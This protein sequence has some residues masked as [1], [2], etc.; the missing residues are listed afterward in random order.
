MISPTTPQ[1]RSRSRPSRT[2]ASAPAINRDSRSATIRETRRHAASALA[3]KELHGEFVEA[4]YV[5]TNR[6]EIDAL[7]ARLERPIDAIEVW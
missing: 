6:E 7:K 2:N 1:S 4:R 3:Q 5:V